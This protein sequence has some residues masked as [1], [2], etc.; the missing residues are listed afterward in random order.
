MI[1]HKV[2]QV[3]PCVLIILKTNKQKTHPAVIIVKV[4]K[5]NNRTSNIK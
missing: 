5:I 1:S 2:S 4:S 3:I